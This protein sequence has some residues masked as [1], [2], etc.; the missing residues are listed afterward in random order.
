MSEYEYESQPE[1]P[2]TKRRHP[3]RT[4]LLVMVS[5]VVVAGLVA[6]GYLFNLARTFDDQTNTIDNAFP[7]EDVARPTAAPEAEG[8]VNILLLGSDARTAEL[9]STDSTDSSNAR[10]DTMMLLHLPA[11][12]SEV[13]VISIMRDTWTDIPGYGANKVNSAMA[14]GG[15]PLVVQTV[16]SM[17][18]AP[19]NHVA[20]VDFEGFKGVTEALDGVEVDNPM[21][22]VS[23]NPNPE[24]FPQGK[25]TLEGD[26]ALRFVR[27]RYAFADGDYQRVK[28]QQLFVKALLGKVLSTDTLTNPARVQNLVSELAP[29]ISADDGLDA[30]TVGSL[31]VS[32]RNAREDDVRFFT[33]PN[34]GIGTSADGQSV[35]LEDEAAMAELRQALDNDSLGD[36][37]A[38]SGVEN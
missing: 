15:I 19:I 20:V 30:A 29:F 27:E 13:F 6:G 8:S 2:K 32:L 28:N 12:R 4:T 1:R 22:F 11:D 14:L 5:L 38:A 26:S 16:E 34:L 7:A 33:L 36:F 23:S 21:N 10:A 18:E 17:F 25:I 31:G 37:L 3:V 24:V 9:G 35:I